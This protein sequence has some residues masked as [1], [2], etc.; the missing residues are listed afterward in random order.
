MSDGGADINRALGVLMG[1]VNA[2]G[3]QLT[4]TRH[5]MTTSEKKSDESRGNMHRRLDEVRSEIYGLKMTSANQAAAIEGLKGSVA[6]MQAVTD[7]VK[8]LRQ[9]A[10]G[11]GTLGQWLIKIGIAVLAVAGWVVSAYTYLT[12]RP[13]P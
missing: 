10:Q 7:D 11:A 1:K 8:A 4:Q 2:I 5:D 9:Q 13:P 6:E 3:E 12:G